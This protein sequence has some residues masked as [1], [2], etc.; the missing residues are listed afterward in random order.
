[1]Q[2][3]K[4]TYGRARTQEQGLARGHYKCSSFIHCMLREEED[5]SA[6]RGERRTEEVGGV[7]KTSA[8]KVSCG[9]FKRRLIIFGA[10]EK[11]VQN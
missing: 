7:L 4:K 2:K 10:T 3:R 6:E 11:H 5:G 9:N 8:E 1:M